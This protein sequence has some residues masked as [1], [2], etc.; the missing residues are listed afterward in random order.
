MALCPS[1]KAKNYITG[2][3]TVRY[4]LPDI[5]PVHLRYTNIVYVYMRFMTF[6]LSAAKPCI[7][8]LVEYKSSSSFKSKRAIYRLLVSTISRAMPDSFSSKKRER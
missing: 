8:C 3:G 2:I 5:W 6:F 1:G 7:A 4:L